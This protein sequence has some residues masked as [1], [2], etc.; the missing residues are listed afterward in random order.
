MLLNSLMG[1]DLREFFIYLLLSLPIVFLSLSVHETAHGFVAY[2]LGDPTARNYGRLT[3]NPIKHIDPIGFI[4]MLFFGFGWAKPVPVN[5]RYFKKPRRDMALTGVAGPISNLLLAVI[6]ALLLRLVFALCTPISLID[7][8]TTVDFIWYFL[9]QM[10]M[11][12][13]QINI[14]F[15]VFNMIPIPPLDG[16]RLLFAFLPPAQYFKF[17][18]YERYISIGLMLALFL[19]FLDKPINFVTNL[20]WNLITTLIF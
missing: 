2:K 11:L 16:S 1:G 20:F 9:W 5:S 3:L 6:F 15:A 18:R 12:G 7:P 4:C 17:M 14:T 8:T 10:L 13:M 19:G